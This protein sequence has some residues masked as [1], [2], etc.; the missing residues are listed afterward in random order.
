MNEPQVVGSITF[1]ADDT[2]PSIAQLEYEVKNLRE[3]LQ[4][5]ND[6]LREYEQRYFQE[7]R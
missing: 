3:Q 7:A 1:A 4:I 6:K 2:K 5:A